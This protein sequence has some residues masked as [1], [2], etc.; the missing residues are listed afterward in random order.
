MRKKSHSVVLN[1]IKLQKKN[2]KNPI[3]S[4]L[5]IVIDRKK[6]AK[7][8]AIAM[9]T[10]IG[11][12]LIS[13]SAKE[14]MKSAYRINLVTSIFSTLVEK[15]SSYVIHLFCRSYHFT[16]QME[17]MQCARDTQHRVTM[18]QNGLERRKEKKKKD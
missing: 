8:N 13:V 10:A 6:N 11:A 14:D 17:N 4:S 1:W 15:Y 5:F 16:D 12:V 3:L 2:H 9:A 18:G 7:N